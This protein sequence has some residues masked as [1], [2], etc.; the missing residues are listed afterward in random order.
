MS[1]VLGWL[2]SEADYNCAF[3]EGCPD[4]LPGACWGQRFGQRTVKEIWVR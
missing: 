3:Y 4:V 2:R 1:G